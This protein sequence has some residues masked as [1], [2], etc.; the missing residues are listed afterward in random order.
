MTPIDPKIHIYP[1]FEEKIATSAPFFALEAIVD[2]LVHGEI[3]CAKFGDLTGKERKRAIDHILE[4]GKQGYGSLEK[5]E[6]NAVS[7][8]YFDKDLL[9]G[10]ISTKNDCTLEIYAGLVAM[11]IKYNTGEQILLSETF[12]KTLATPQDYAPEKTYSLGQMINFNNGQQG[13]VLNRTDN[14]KTGNKNLMSVA[15]KRKQ[16][17]G[18]RKEEQYGYELREYEICHYTINNKPDYTPRISGAN[19][20]I[21]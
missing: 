11:L 6:E 14:D 18:L 7:E 21:Y 8:G 19:I 16:K 12:V 3:I 15:K 4:H 5:M 13:V 9:K 10:I 17:I 2:V 1:V 20:Q